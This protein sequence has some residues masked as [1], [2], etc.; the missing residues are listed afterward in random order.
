M[1]P[2]KRPIVKSQK[3]V[4]RNAVLSIRER[5]RA[6]CTRMRMVVRE[7]A[8]V[9]RDMKPRTRVAQPKPMEGCRLWKTMG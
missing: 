1:K 8:R 9:V 7:M 3:E 5:L 2:K 4:E 6:G